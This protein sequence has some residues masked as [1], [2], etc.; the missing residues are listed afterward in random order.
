MDTSAP[1]PAMPRAPHLILAALLTACGPTPIEV[2]PPLAPAPPPPAP[3]RDPVAAARPAKP[4][5]VAVDPPRSRRF[6]TV[7]AARPRTPV[8]HF[9][10]GQRV[11]IRVVDAHWNHDGGPVFF[12][13]AGSAGQACGVLGRA[14]VG[15]DAAPLMGLFLITA[16][17]RPT[18]DEVACAPE[19]R[20]FVPQGVEFAVPED[21]EIALGPNDWEDGLGDNRGSLKVDVEVTAGQRGKVIWKKRVDVAAAVARTSLGRFRAG[22]YVRVT[23]IGGGWSNDPAAPLYSAAGAARERCRSLDVHRCLGGDTAVPMMGLVLS[24]GACLSSPTRPREQR[25]F[26]PDG[27]D[28]TLI[29]ESDLFL[30][31]NDREDACGDNAGAVIVEV[32]TD[33]R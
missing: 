23:V 2:A 21:T 3:P 28:V 16:P 11:R 32:E 10:A 15:D 20:L 9:L 1:L 8:G 13:A 6:V 14:C 27:A 30:G 29:R 18:A 4:L 19:H 12:G 31:P 25:R 7:D 33:P 24:M 26:V 22:Q 17:T 5:Q